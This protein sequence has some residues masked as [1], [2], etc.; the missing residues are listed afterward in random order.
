MMKIDIPQY[1]QDVY[2]VVRLIPEGKVSTYGIIADYLSLGSAR[3][4]GWALNKCHVMEDFVPAHRVVNR[5]GELSGRKMFSTPTAMA[6]AL[7]AEGIKIQ[8]GEK[9]MG[10]EN[11]LWYP[12]EHLF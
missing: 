4:V 1:W 12:T 5:K 3:M 8:N 6:D 2:D 9:V 10:F 7:T 11:H